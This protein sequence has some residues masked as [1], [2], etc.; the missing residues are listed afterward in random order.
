MS[1]PK[2]ILA[3]AAFITILLGEFAGTLALCMSFTTAGPQMAA[4]FGGLLV[5]LWTVIGFS[6]LA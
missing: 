1:D 4:F 2:I 6:L 3:T 5:M